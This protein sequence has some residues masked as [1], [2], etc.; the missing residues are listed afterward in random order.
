MEENPLV[1][2][3][4]PITNGFAKEYLPKN[5]QF[6]LDIFTGFYLIN[7]IGFASLGQY[8]LAIRWRVF[9]QHYKKTLQNRKLDENL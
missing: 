5:L 7:I 2:G 9:W 8:S 1:M 4:E 3:D 6:V